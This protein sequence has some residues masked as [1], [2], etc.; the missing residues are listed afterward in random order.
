MTPTEF[1]DL[2]QRAVSRDVEALEELLALYQPMIDRFSRVD[3]QMD[4]DLR[5]HLL[6]TYCPQHF[7]VSDLKKFF[8]LRFEISGKRKLLVY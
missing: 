8:Q 7:P 2:L 4:E 5:Q 6:F 3:G 1:R